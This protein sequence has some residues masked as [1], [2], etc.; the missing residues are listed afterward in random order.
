MDRKDLQ[1]LSRVRLKEAKALLDAGLPDGAYYLAG[2]A[3]ECALKACIAKATKRHEFPDLTR[4]RDSYVHKIADLVKLA[5]L[6]ENRRL[7]AADDEG[8]NENWVIVKEW[9]EN[10]RY[11]RNDLDTARTLLRA[12]ED[13]DHGIIPWIRQYW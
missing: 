7:L 5:G 1:T 11:S 9:S 4:V 12:I 10:S 8:F 6:E 13:R 3:V 2:Y